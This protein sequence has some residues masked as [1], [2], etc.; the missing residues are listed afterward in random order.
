MGLRFTDDPARTLVKQLKVNQEVL[1]RFKALIPTEEPNDS[2]MGEGVG[3]LD[4]NYSYV[5]EVTGY[6]RAKGERES[7][8]L[9]ISSDD[10]MSLHEIE[11]TALTMN[12]E[13]PG[14]QLEKAVVDIKRA[15]KSKALRGR[16]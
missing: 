12:S 8:G 7:Y 16:L 14:Y 9:T 10:L 11:D 15:V 1:K 13:E 3:L 2:D 4:K 6:N 5:V